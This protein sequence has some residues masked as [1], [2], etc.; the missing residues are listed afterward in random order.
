MKKEEHPWCA[1]CGEVL[2]NARNMCRNLTRHASLVN[3]PLKFFQQT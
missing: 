3:K 1:K 2:I